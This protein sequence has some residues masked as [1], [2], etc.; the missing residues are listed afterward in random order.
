[1]ICHCV[2]LLPK[3]TWPS[4]SQMNKNKCDKVK[5]KPSSLTDLPSQESVKLIMIVAVRA[6]PLPMRK[7]WNS[8]RQFTIKR[9]PCR[10]RPWRETLHSSV[11]QTTW[12]LE[13]RSGQI[14]AAVCLSPSSRL[15]SGGP[16]VVP[17]L[18]AEP[19]CRG[20]TGE[21]YHQIQFVPPL[22]ATAHFRKYSCRQRC[23]QRM[24]T[25]DG[26]GTIPVTTSERPETAM[27]NYRQLAGLEALL[28][29][30][31]NDNDV[32]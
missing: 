2:L 14:S 7:L 31:N 17:G 15:D 4:P 28:Q 22:R 29:I 20:W 6:T 21:V 11:V 9:K 27:P 3:L 13:L 25:S 30:L 10:L 18:L 26:R 5:T 32:L 24:R 16:K 19:G 23:G 12:W 1:M 8:G